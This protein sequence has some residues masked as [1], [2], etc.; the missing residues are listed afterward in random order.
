MNKQASSYRDPSGFVFK[1]KDKVRRQVNNFYKDNYDFLIKSGLYKRLSDKKLLVAH[2]EI[3]TAK[4]NGRYKII[5]PQQIPFISYP[6]E[7]CFSQLKDAALL[8]LRI[9]KIALDHD[10]SLKDASS[11]NVQFFDNSPI[12]I[13]TLSFERYKEGKPWIAYRQFCEHFLAPLALASYCDPYLIKLLLA[14]VG[15]IPI[16]VAARTLPLKARFKPMLFIHL[17]MQAK[18]VNKDREELKKFSKQNFYQLVRSLEECVKSLHLKVDKTK[19]SHYYEECSLKN[20]GDKKLAVKKK[21]VRRYL[22]ILKPKRVWDLGA[23][24]GEFS[25]IS[26]KRGIFTV[27]M[28]Y[29]L[30]S[31][32]RNYLSAKREK[33]KKMLPLIVD[34]VNPT[35]GIGWENKERDELFDRPHPDTILALALVHHLAIGN[36]L[37]LA[38][39][40]EY[41]SKLTNS[42][43]IEFV[44]KS[45][46]QVKILLKDREDIFKDYDER[47]FE[48]ELGN[49]F[50]IKERT[51]LSKSGRK[52]YLMVRK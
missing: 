27:S 16:E 10:M 38:S 46:R 6:Y 48:K 29:D 44:P 5:E 20:Y 49:F 1:C 30:L 4:E 13:D 40:A 33:L 26:S 15:G 52:L 23:N 41:F 18:N 32:E 9:Q 19:W 12:F 8:T 14:N 31:I 39:I 34:F 42:L 2:K 24:T 50:I 37:P 36:N 11:F 25:K 51:V 22:N 21:A 3:K 28:D 7:W 17:F 45:D 47:N 43:I 35:P